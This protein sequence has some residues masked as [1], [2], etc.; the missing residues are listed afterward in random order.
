MTPRSQQT[1]PVVLIHGAWAGAWV[2]ERLIPFLIPVGLVCWAVNLPGNGSDGVDPATI[3]FESY[4]DR[5]RGIID[6]FDRPVSL[7]AHSGGGNVATAVAERWPESVS[8]IVYIAGMML[9]DGA[10]FGDVVARASERHPTAAGI[11]PHTV[12]SPDR[13]VTQ[14]PPDAAIAHFFHDCDPDDARAA[15]NRLTPQGEGGRAVVTHTSA[16]RFGRVPRLYVEALFDKSVILPV[17]RL[18]QTLVPGARVTSLPTGHAPQLSAPA[19]LAEEIIPFL[20]AAAAT[21]IRRGD[22]APDTNSLSG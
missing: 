10:T 18:M 5:M 3:S 1:D 21:L 14:V 16:A 12:W 4:L 7:V 19:L 2:W 9:P 22:S 6:K 11:D 13:R 8:R 15:A 20:T 17:Q